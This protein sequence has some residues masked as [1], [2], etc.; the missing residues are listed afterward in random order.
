MVMSCLATVLIL[1]PRAKQHVA[2]SKHSKICYF[3]RKLKNILVRSFTNRLIEFA[4]Q[5]VV[6]SSI[7]SFAIDTLLVSHCD[8]I[9]YMD[10]LAKEKYEGQLFI[11]S[12]RSTVQKKPCDTFSSLLPSLFQFQISLLY[13]LFERQSHQRNMVYDSACL[14]NYLFVNTYKRKQIQRNCMI[15]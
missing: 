12:S 3:T 14:V 11:D 1:H 13:I 4:T 2:A 8:V 10:M 7:C 9:K 5:K 6:F 15:M